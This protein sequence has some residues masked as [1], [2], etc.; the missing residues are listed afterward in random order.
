M[1]ARILFNAGDDLLSQHFPAPQQVLCAHH[2]DEV[3]GVVAAAEQEARAGRWV[4]GMVAYEAAPAFDAVLMVKPPLPDFPLA[5]FAVYPDE[6]AESTS[7]AGPGD[8][9]CEP[10]RMEI[11]P[12]R[13][14]EDIAA[15]QAD[16][17]N[18]RY[19]QA[20]HTARLRSPCVGAASA[21]FAALQRAQPGGY[22]F[23][24]DA[25]SW[26]VLSVSPELFF[27]WQPAGRLVARPMKGTAPRHDDPAADERSARGLRASAKEQAENLMI[28]DL[29][30]N[31]LSRLAVTGS[32][33]V[34]RLFTVEALP[35]LWQMTSTVQCD[36][37]PATTLV[38]VFTALFPC[39][40]VTGAPKVTA[41]QAINEREVSPRGPYCG[42][43]GVIRPGGHATFSV[44]I[45][46]VLLQ[47]GQAQ[48]GIGSG[49]TLDATTAGEFAEWQAKRRFLW[50]ASAGFQLI[51]TLKLTDG[52]YPL[53]HRHLARLAA[54]AAHFGF[55]WRASAVQAVLQ[56]VASHHDQGAWR[57]RLLLGRDG[58][59]DTEAFAL[60]ATP[61]AYAVAWASAPVQSGDEFL[62]HKTTHRSMYAPHV[63]AA[64][65]GLFDTLLYNERDEITEFTRGNVVVA[66]DGRQ[67]TPAL[68]CGLLP[69]TLRAELLDKGEIAEAVI[70]RSDL[71]RAEGLWFING[72]RGRVPCRL[73][74]TH[75]AHK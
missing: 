74:G 58:H 13:F 19:Y 72:V 36:T 10:W 2:L 22:G 21:L 67:L 4:V 49:I 27:D 29:L 32:V 11:D 52:M 59:L 56:G 12:A 64:D 16:I 39:G 70:H 20:N 25:D 37:A 57:V 35:S 68:S 23:Y 6:V 8:W 24:L 38:D 62:R 1:E 61:E 33:T 60:E 30:R 55:V 50:R 42:A 44:G 51:E 48:C 75:S 41:M 14:A 7:T 3:R 9:I 40:S 43:L 46:T 66:L 45:R 26:Q 54:S 15:L 17:V 5:W 47:S 31:D 73:V 18:G 34:P 28:V 65:S 53:L 69:G 71:T 63:P